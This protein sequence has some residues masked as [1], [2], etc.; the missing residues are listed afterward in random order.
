MS[1]DNSFDRTVKLN[2]LI[3]DIMCQCASIKLT[4]KYDDSL[5]ARWIERE[6]G[7]MVN[8][9]RVYLDE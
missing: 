6:M 3:M 1:T 7:E 8:K 5:T 4:A 9:V 2:Q